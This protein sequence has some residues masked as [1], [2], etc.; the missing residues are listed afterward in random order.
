MAACKIS[1]V[2]PTFN[3]AKALPLVVADIRKYSAGYDT[4]IL[5]VDS[6]KDDTPAIAQSL[7]V[8]VLS[9]PPQGHGIALRTAILAASGDYIVTADCDDTY[10]MDRLPDFIDLLQNQGYDVVSGNRLGTPEVYRAMP[11]ANRCANWSFAFL[12]RRL[13]GIPT[14]DVTT[15]MFG[16]RRAAANAVAWETNRS[17]PAEIIIRSHL[18]GLRYLEVPISYKLRVGEVTLQRW[19]SGKAYLRCFLKYRFHLKTPPEKL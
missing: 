2:M 15:G 6:S 12:V 3:E 10:P 13:Y 16:F 17:F 7:G 11:R 19:A 5:I 8:K 9:Q 18:A 14:H 1:V 4:E